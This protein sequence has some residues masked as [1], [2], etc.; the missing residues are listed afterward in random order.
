MNKNCLLGIVALLF[1]CC[2]MLGCGKE[3]NPTTPTVKYGT[4]Y[5]TVAD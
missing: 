1:V 2:A 5:G 4:I 3:D